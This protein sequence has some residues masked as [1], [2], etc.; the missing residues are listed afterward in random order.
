MLALQVEA[1]ITATKS[2]ARL[3]DFSRDVW[4]VWAAGTLSDDE[5]QRLAT[6]IEA[7]KGRRARVD[8]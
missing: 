5:A 7:R 1:A 8:V 6:L 3:D 2:L 4:K